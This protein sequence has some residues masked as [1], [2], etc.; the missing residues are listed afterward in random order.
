M[1]SQII[2]QSLNY[3][4]FLPCNCASLWRCYVIGLYENIFIYIKVSGLEEKSKVVYLI[5]EKRQTIYPR[6]KIEYYTNMWSWAKYVT[7]LIKWTLNCKFFH[8]L[9]VISKR[10]C[11]FFSTMTVTWAIAW[12]NG[13]YIPAAFSL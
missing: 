13:E 3:L 2:S 1:W 4:S 11:Y 8:Q 6:N 9:L 5:E 10:S 7:N 12:D